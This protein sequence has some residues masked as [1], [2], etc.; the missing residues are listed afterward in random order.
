MGI[1]VGPIPSVGIH[2][3]VAA[4]AVVYSRRVRC[5]GV[6][7]EMTKD[8]LA[9]HVREL[10]DPQCRYYW[11]IRRVIP[12]V[13]DCLHFREIGK[14]SDKR[15]RTW[16]CVDCGRSVVLHGSVFNWVGSSGGKWRRKK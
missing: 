13:S 16:K 15:M 9:Q 12:K 10:M 6:T 3:S 1:R 11:T 8:D 5:G 4:C 14:S 2:S 7:H